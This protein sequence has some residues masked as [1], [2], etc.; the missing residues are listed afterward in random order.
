MFVSNVDCFKWSD[1]IATEAIDRVKNQS[2]LLREGA[3]RKPLDEKQ[4]G[5]Q[6]HA[7]EELSYE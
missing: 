3:S 4:N 5:V 1:E 7:I 2:V 6:V